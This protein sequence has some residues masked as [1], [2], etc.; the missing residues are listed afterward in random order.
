M[1]SPPPQPSLSFYLR[2]LLLKRVVLA[3][4]SDFGVHAIGEVWA[5]FLFVMTENLIAKHGFSNTLFPPTNVTESND[6][7]VD[8]AE[9]DAQGQLKKPL[10]PKHG[11]TLAV[12]LVMNGMK[13]QPCRPSCVLPF[14]YPNHTAV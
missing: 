10:V 8:A 2:L 13:L 5:Q 4:S 3:C 11:N 6:Y 12:Q 14:P 1:S 9:V 7:Y